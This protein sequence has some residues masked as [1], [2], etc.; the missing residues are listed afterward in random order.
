MRE[1]YVMLFTAQS[2][3]AVDLYCD[4]TASVNGIAGSYKMPHARDGKAILIE[5]VEGEVFVF[6][7]MHQAL[8]IRTFKGRPCT[9]DCSGHEAGYSW[10]ERNEIEDASDCDGGKSASF[11]EGCQIYVEENKG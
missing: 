8:S 1:R 5:T 11:I 10:A 7:K 4:K 6:T 9:G 2:K 3:I